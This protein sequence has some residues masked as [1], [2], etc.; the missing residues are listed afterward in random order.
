MSLNLE[1][2]EE[3]AAFWNEAVLKAIDDVVVATS[4]ANPTQ[5]HKHQHQHQ[6]SRAE[7]QIDHHHSPPRELSQRVNESDTER[8]KEKERDRD[9]KNEQLKSAVSQINAGSVREPFEADFQDLFQ[10]A[11]SSIDQNKKKHRNSKRRGKEMNVI[12]ENS[13]HESY[14]P[15]QRNVQTDSSSVMNDSRRRVL[16][17]GALSTSNEGS[18][19]EAVLPEARRQ[20]GS[21]SKAIGVQTDVYDEL[22]KFSPNHSLSNKLHAIWGSHSRFSGRDLVSKLFVTCSTDFHFL[23]RCIGTNMPSQITLNSLTDESLSCISS[24]GHS[25]EAAKVSRLFFILTKMSNGMVQLDIL[26]DALLDLCALPNVIVSHT[27]L[28]IVHAILLYVLSLNIRPDRSVICSGTMLQL[29]LCAL[30]GKM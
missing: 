15:A 18:M 6:Q 13:I 5:P 4:S 8:L 9:K 16:I 25:V 19:Q 21:S 22:S 28:R 17:D 30:R 26:F 27:S 20:P 10:P 14:S 23:S 3:D 1:E 2:L 11:S 29:N 12:G 7:L 24:H